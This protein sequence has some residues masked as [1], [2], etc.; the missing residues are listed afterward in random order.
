MDHEAEELE[1]IIHSI[2]NPEPTV[3][4]E[5]EE[6]YETPPLDRLKTE[7][8]LDLSYWRPFEYGSTSPLMRRALNDRDEISTVL[9]AQ[10]VPFE[11]FLGTLRL[12]GDSIIAY[13]P[14]RLR[15]G[16]YR[17]YPAILMS[18]WASFEAFVRTYS[19]LFVK[20]VPNLPPTLKSALLEQEES[21]NEKGETRNRKR[22]QPILQRYWWLLKFGYGVEH[23][24]GS[25]IWQLGEE[26][27][28]K[29][30]ELVHYE[31]STLPS[32]RTTELWQHLESI[33]LLLIGPSAQARKSIMPKQ[34]ELY[35]ILDDL[36]PLME[37]FEERPHFKDWPV[38]VEAVIFPCPF[39]NVDQIQYPTMSQPLRP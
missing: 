23:D 30:N 26:A 12:F 34:Y 37:E 28:R 20:T 24:R 10:Q 39:Q 29:R 27:L 1:G 2:F 31:I 5:G 14:E 16:P 38:R 25:R 36:R 8:H 19:E 3:G 17:Y 7:Y 6:Y 11:L 13:H 21:I 4:N 35:G 32:L 15:S 33:L 9:Q 22:L 18:A